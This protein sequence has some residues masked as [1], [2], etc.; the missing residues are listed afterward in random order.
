MQELWGC[1]KRQIIKGVYQGVAKFFSDECSQKN[2]ARSFFKIFDL[3]NFFSHLITDVRPS[4][5]E[6][7]FFKCGKK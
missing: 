2:L 3:F 6:L 5:V 4:I 1:D 7:T